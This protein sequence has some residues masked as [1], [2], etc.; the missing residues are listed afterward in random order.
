MKGAPDV[1]LA[2]CAHQAAGGDPWTAEPVQ[3]DVWLNVAAS[4]SREGMRVLALC[5]A[6]EPA[7]RAPTLHV[8]DILSGPPRLQINALV[9]VLDPPRPEA[10]TAVREMHQAGI[11]VNMIT[12]DHKD[13]AATIGRWVGIDAGPGGVLTGSQMETMTDQELA[14]RVESTHIYARATPEHKLRI[15]RALQGHKHVVVMTGT[16]CFA[17]L[18]QCFA[19]SVSCCAYCCTSLANSGQILAASH[20]NLRTSSLQATV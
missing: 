15:V 2:R 18:F 3:R 17:W 8:A 7:D 1:L 20:D 16:R 10:I 6:E 13:T 12:G 14:A 19:V 9:A 5:Q 4:M 11:V